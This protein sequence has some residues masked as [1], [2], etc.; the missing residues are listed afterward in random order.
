MA[1]EKVICNHCKHECHCDTLVCNYCG[2][3]GCS[4]DEVPYKS[5][6]PDWG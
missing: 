2:C 3:S 4:H 5:N 6:Y 1:D